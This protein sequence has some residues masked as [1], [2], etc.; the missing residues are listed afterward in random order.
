MWAR[1]FLFGVGMVLVLESLNPLPLSVHSSF[2]Q[3][4]FGHSDVLYHGKENNGNF[5]VGTV[6]VLCPKK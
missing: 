4:E 2:S 3:L 5:F 6:S 1:I